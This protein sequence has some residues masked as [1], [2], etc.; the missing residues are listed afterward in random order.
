MYYNLEI[1]DPAD[2]ASIVSTADL[3]TFLRVDHSDEDTLIGALRS[4][5]IEYVQ[6]YCNLQLGDVT[7]IMYLD[8]FHGTWE[9][10]VGPVRS[11]T[12]IVYNNTPTTTLTLSTDNYY[13]DLK[14]K[15]ARITTISP[16]AVHPD[17]SNGV[18]VTMELGYLEAEVPDGLVHAVKLLVAHFYE[19]RNI[20]VIGTIS[21]EVPNLIHS[22]LNPYRV[23]SDR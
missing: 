7:A 17:T 15:P 18:Q 6:N 14:R 1:V 2:E 10:P 16:P 9:I 23:I 4:A 11:I 19:N 13:T 22:L 12:S 5:A 21:S 8:N 3:K 20:V